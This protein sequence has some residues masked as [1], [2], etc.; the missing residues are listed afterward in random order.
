MKPVLVLLTFFLLTSTRTSAWGPDIPFASQPSGRIS[1]VAN[2]AGT[3]YCTVPAA[4]T[5]VGGAN[6]Y[7]STDNGASWMPIAN[8]GSG[9]TVEKTKLLVTGTDSV[10]CIYQIGVDLFTF[11]VQSREVTP[12]TTMD[13]DD[14]D[15]TASPN[16][17][18]IYLFTDDFGNLNVHR[19]SSTDGGYTWT[20][21][22]A[23]VAGNAANPRVCMDGT[24]LILNYYGP[25]LSPATTSIIRSA[26]YNETVPGTI[27]PGAGAFADRLPSG[28]TRPQFESAIVANTVW[29]F[30]TETNGIDISLKYMV[31]SDN[32]V[33]YSTEATVSNDAACF[34]LTTIRSIVDPAVGLA[35]YHDSVPVAPNYRYSQVR[36]LNPTAFSSPESFS[37]FDPSCFGGHETYPAV[38]AIGNDVGVVWTE[39]DAFASLYF[40]LRSA[41]TKVETVSPKGDIRVYPNPAGDQ[42]SIRSGQQTMGTR[43]RI[44]DLSGQIVQTIQ[45]ESG[46]TTI[47][48]HLLASGVYQL[49][50][51]SG[52]AT[53][54]MKN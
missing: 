13:V 5:G 7:E 6:L 39:T 38:A 41:I 20:G 47:D 22:T 33:N 19:Y 43:Y 23:L 1:M 15:A 52:A 3:L 12:F 42:I 14:F 45:L 2:S 54:F 44:V 16:G 21:S 11:S 29:L 10:Y 18:A 49:V 32:G 17:N 25:V 37:D 51:E 26:F 9:Q 24:R 4:M 36:A 48:I 34:G 28:P 27:A 50:G 30:W 40:D 8:L 46:I 35:Y 53:R 31:S